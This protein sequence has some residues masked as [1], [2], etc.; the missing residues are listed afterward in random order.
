MPA[1]YRALHW[2]ASTLP[3]LHARLDLHTE[4]KGRMNDGTRRAA[5]THA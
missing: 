3:N 4:G 2:P 1:C 5:T